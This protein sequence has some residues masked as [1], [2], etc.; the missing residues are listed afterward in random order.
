MKKK[1]LIILTFLLLTLM[2]IVVFINRRH[3]EY[4]AYSKPEK[5]YAA[6]LEECV[7]QWK[8]YEDDYPAGDRSQ[9]KDLLD[10]WVPVNGT[11]SLKIKK[12]AEFLLRHLDDQ[13]GVPSV[14][15]MAKSPL[16]QFNHLRLHSEERLWCGNWSNIYAYFAWNRHI[17]TRIIEVLKPGDHHVFNESYVEEL[18]QWVLID[19]TNNTVMPRDSA[20]NLLNGFSYAQYKTAS[21]KEDPYFNTHYP[22]YYYRRYHLGSVYSPESRINRYLSP[23]P[24]YEI[25][26]TGNKPPGNFLFYVKLI[27]AGL[28]LVV[29]FVMIMNLLFTRK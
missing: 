7:A 26:Q 28:W 18:N 12:L 19:L 15:L 2:N 21:G 14:E 27:V 6:C 13:R 29:F 1:T 4:E 20:G 17:P 3:F 8:Q 16:G 23:Q 25:L 9:V 22:W 5:L 11:T 10:E 24:W